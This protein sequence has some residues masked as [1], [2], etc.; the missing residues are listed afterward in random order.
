M[1]IPYRYK[2]EFVYKNRGYFNE[3]AKVNWY[4]YVKGS[5]IRAEI[6][7][8]ALRAR[9]ELGYSINSA[10]CDIVYNLQRVFDKL[11]HSE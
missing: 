7:Y 9:M 2:Q 5:I 11:N 4:P 1:N 10:D 3:I 6:K 8:I